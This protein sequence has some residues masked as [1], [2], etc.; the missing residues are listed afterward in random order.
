MD[1]LLAY[2]RNVSGIQAGQRPHRPTKIAI[3]LGVRCDK[4]KLELSGP[5]S[6]EVCVCWCGVGPLIAALVAGERSAEKPSIAL[7]THHSIALD[8]KGFGGRCMFEMM[9]HVL[10][11]MRNAPTAD[12]ILMKK[13]TITRSSGYMYMVEDNTSSV[14]REAW[15][16][17]RKSA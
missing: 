5:L 6:T 1:G 11:S 9:I 10:V 4:L 12:P 8:A 7:V 15:R 14:Y 16:G 13:K 17:C 3:I 2:V